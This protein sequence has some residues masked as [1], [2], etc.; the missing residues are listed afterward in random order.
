[1]HFTSILELVTVDKGTKVFGGP[2]D[3]QGISA[4]EVRFFC[5]LSSVFCLL[6][7]IFAHNT[8]F[9]HVYEGSVYPKEA[10]LFDSDSDLSL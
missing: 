5:S 9:C 1:M 6:S 3:G 7:V 2:R 8:R 4:S 10:S